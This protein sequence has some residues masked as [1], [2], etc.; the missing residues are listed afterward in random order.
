MTVFTVPTVTL[1][2]SDGL[3]GGQSVDL[4]TLK[5]VRV[6]QTLSLPTQCELVFSQNE[7]ID[8]LAN[9]VIERLVVGTTVRLALAA[10]T[11]VL[12]AGQVTAIEYRYLPDNEVELR[13]RCYDALHALRKRQSVRSY[14]Q[15]RALDLAREMMS[16]L[17]V[18]VVLESAASDP[19]HELIIQH[20][21]ND[22][23]LLQQTLATRGLFF[24]LRDDTLHLLPLTGM[25]G[26]VDLYLGESLLEVTVAVNSDRAVRSVAVQGWDP[27]WMELFE[28]VLSSAQSGR[29]VQA[30]AAP[31]NVNGFDEVEIGDVDSADADQ[32]DAIAQ[33][34]LD[35]RTASEVT[36]NGVAFGDPALRPGTI[37]NVDGLHH[38]IVGNYVLTD[39]IHTIDAESGYLS[40]IST[41]PPQLPA[42]SSTAAALIGTVTQVD[43][44]QALGRI[45]VSYPSLNDVESDWMQV[46]SPAA[47]VNKGLVA[48]PDNGDH[49][50]VLC[51]NQNPT[52]GIVLGGIY[53]P[54]APY[55][56][57][58]DG[59]S[60]TRYSLRTPDGHIVQLDDSTEK[61]RIEN[62]HGSYVEMEPEKVRLYANTDLEIAAPG[63]AIVIKGQSVD[64]QRE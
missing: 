61:V 8:Q 28:S 25:Q 32:S 31:A 47:G 44:P 29:D 36:L 27:L 5:S 19:I 6:Q 9:D 63:R 53:G 1:T 12:F 48:L 21:Q 7:A 54:Y 38:S 40:T 2:I 22:F 4:T 13:V 42:K 18:T 55:D 57:G 14:V 50:L 59:S 52:R 39:V 62:S 11:P 20:G 34:I 24:T 64:F 17:G 30:T 41:H 37:I 46:M 45:K 35:Q 51:L 49:V 15:T 43:D 16:D 26:T 60:I 23:E 33:A 56:S 10:Q 3:F 58:V